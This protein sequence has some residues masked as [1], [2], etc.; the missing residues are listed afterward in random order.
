MKELSKQMIEDFGK[1]F[2]A[3]NIKNMQQFYLMQVA[4][5]IQ[6]LE[7][8]KKPEDVIRDIYVLEFLGLTSN[9]DFYESDLE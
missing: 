2:N 4:E 1:G 3:E 9:D 8:T 5:E 6:I 7:P